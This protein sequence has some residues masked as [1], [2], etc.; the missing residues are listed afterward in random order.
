MKAIPSQTESQTRVPRGLGAR[1]GIPD[2]YTMTAARWLSLALVVL[3]I[4]LGTSSIL[5]PVGLGLMR[6]RTSP[7]TAW[8]V[9]P[10]TPRPSPKLERTAAVMLLL[11]AVFLVFGLHLRSILTAWRDSFALTEYASSPTPFWMVKLM[12]LGIV[13]P[14][15]SR[16]GGGAPEG[17]AWARRAMYVLLTGYSCLAVAVAAMAVV[18][19]VNADPDASLVLVGGFS[20]VAVAF[21]TLTILL[22]RPFFG[23]RSAS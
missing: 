10:A 6:Y 23:V 19:Y 9:A 2:Q 15:S 18:M 20:A 1:P 8:R 5:G 13:V 11:V 17:A 3:A 16:H 4:G 14:G 12:D 21:A 7:T 22:Y